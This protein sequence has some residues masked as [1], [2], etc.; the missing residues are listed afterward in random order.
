MGDAS[1]TLR[2]WNIRREDI[3][4]LILH[5]GTPKPWEKIGSQKCSAHLL[6]VP[7]PVPGLMS[8][9]ISISQTVLP[10]HSALWQLERNAQGTSNHQDETM[11][12]WQLMAQA[13]MYQQ[14]RKQCR[15]HPKWSTVFTLRAVCIWSLFAV[16]FHQP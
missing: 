9:F 4:T 16:C 8:I 5:M 13:G 11:L 10:D 7:V 1:L 2:M 15:S 6:A 14:T 3:I 12:W